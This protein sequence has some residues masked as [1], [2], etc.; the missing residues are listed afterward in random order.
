MSVQLL[1]ALTAKTCICLVV[2]PAE[3]TDHILFCFHGHLL[4]PASSSST[5]SGGI[6]H[7][8]YRL[9]VPATGQGPTASP[10][11]WL[12]R[13]SLAAP[14]GKRSRCGSSQTSW[15]LPDQFF[16]RCHA[17][18]SSFKTSLIAQSIP[19]PDRFEKVANS[20]KRTEI[21]PGWSRVP[22]GEM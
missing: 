16:H 21:I 15:I 4:S 7:L 22:T 18:L 5:L 1:S 9:M 6:V 10:V 19:Y 8:I 17:G 12:P 14:S 20:D 2:L 11:S 3:R 13:R